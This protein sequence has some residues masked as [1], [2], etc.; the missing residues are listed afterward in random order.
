MGL[1]HGEQ[2]GERPPKALLDKFKEKD[3]PD[4]VGLIEM[5]IE[6]LNHQIRCLD[7]VDPEVIRKYQSLVEDIETISR[8]VEE[9]EKKVC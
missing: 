2:I 4:E 9:F 8:E 6:E 5:R 7:D 3:V 1:G